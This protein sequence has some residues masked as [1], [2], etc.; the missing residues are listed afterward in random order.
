MME[1]R[2]A[3][4]MTA[5]V[6][7]LRPCV[8]TAYRRLKKR[9]LVRA[10][11]LKW[12]L[13]K[14]GVSVR[15]RQVLRR[16]SRHVRSIPL[17]DTCPF[18]LEAL[19]HPVLCVDVPVVG[20]G[21]RVHRYPLDGMKQWLATGRTDPLTRTPL[22]PDVVSAVHRRFQLIYGHG[23]EEGATAPPTPGEDTSDPEGRLHFMS[24]DFLNAV[25]DVV[26]QVTG[27]MPHFLDHILLNNA[28]SILGSYSVASNEI[29][30]ATLQ[31]WWDE[32]STPCL[33]RADAVLSASIRDGEAMFGMANPTLAALKQIVTQ[34]RR[35]DRTVRMMQHGPMSGASTVLSTPMSGGVHLQVTFQRRPAVPL[36]APPLIRPSAAG[37]SAASSLM[38]PEGPSMQPGGSMFVGA[39]PAP[40]PPLVRLPPGMERLFSEEV[41]EL[42]RG[43]S[44]DLD[45][46]MGSDEMD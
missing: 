28:A 42:L 9:D 38:R 43:A 1:I 26:E 44:Q 29:E 41:I 32:E 33:M 30:R 39:L 6:Q 15:A 21:W 22:G 24:V 12:G 19:P 16:F 13:W 23:L 4:L 34:Y 46:E 36:Q 7:E 2:L 5:R 31:A 8:P 35:G 11:V 20:R 10:L 18:T 40:P 45:V 14:L 37:G 25:D 17:N 27:G 3:A